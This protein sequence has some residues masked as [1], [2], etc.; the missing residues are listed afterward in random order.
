VYRVFSAPLTLL[1]QIN[2]RILTS[3]LLT[4]SITML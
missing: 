4:N 1:F 3:K 2:T